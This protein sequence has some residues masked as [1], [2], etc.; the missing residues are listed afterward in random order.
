MPL[1]PA[2]RETVLAAMDRLR[3]PGVAV[4]LLVDGEE[5]TEG[6]GVTSVENPLPVDETTLFQIGSISK[7]FTATAVMSLVEQDKLNLDVPVRTYLPN[8]RLADEEVARR[9]TLRHALNHTSGWPGDIFEDYGPGDDAL[10]KMVD[11]IA[12]LPQLTP[13]GEVWSYNNVAYCLAGR[14]IEIVTGLPFEQ[15]I[16]ELLLDPLGMDRTF[17]RA[18][19]AI[20][21]RCAVGHVGFDDGPQVSRPW[22]LGR[23]THPFAGIASCL[24]DLLQWARFHLGDGTVPGAGSPEGRLLRP[25]TL[26]HM[27]APLAPAGA[28][29]E[30]IGVTFQTVDIAGIRTIGHGGSWCNQLSVFRLAPEQ[31]FA[32]VALTNGHRGAEVHG[33]IVQSAL[34]AYL[35]AR[36]AE[37]RYLT[38]SGADLAAY[39]G[40]YD[41]LLDDVELK[42][43]DE[44][45][46]LTT[47]RRA[48][49]MG[50]VPKPPPPAPVRRSRATRASSCAEITARSPGL[51]GAGGSTGD[52]E[53][54][55]QP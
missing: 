21:H 2:V 43:K 51:P 5:V 7:T 44:T 1:H 30:A 22:A 38:L 40:R 14:A 52:P 17:Y 6:F 19:D 55:R 34:R 12:S 33:E 45:L 31:R 42:V 32:V 47:V 11:R 24:R 54:T 4:G 13:L 23:S 18:S 39:E 37:P 20:T 26:A 3:V 25:E 46:V 35:G 53:R 28:Q 27:H 8:L 9:V 16:K 50:S 15:A 10:A 49:A 29:A 48:N 41:A 36:P